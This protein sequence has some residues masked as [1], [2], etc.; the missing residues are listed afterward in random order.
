MPNHQCGQQIGRLEEGKE[1]QLGQSLANE[2]PVV[3]DDVEE[4]GRHWMNQS[5]FGKQLLSNMSTKVVL[6]E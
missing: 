1:D 3:E 2:Q 4:V 5:P 6:L